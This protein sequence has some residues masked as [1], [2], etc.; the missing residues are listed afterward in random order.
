MRNEGNDGVEIAATEQA[1]QV[2]D[3]ED[4]TRLH[5]AVRRDHWTEFVVAAS[6]SRP[7]SSGQRVAQVGA[8]IPHVHQAR[9]WAVVVE[10]QARSDGVARADA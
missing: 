7:R 6:G 4:V 1:I 5:F 9:L 8:E 2:R 3:S 10:V